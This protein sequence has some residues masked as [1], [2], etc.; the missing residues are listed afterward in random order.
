M[1][2]PSEHPLGILIDAMALSSAG[3]NPS[4]AI[5]MQEA[6]GQAA[7][8]NS[9]LLPV[10][11]TQNVDRWAEFDIDAPD[12]P[13]WAALGFVLGPIITDD[14]DKRGKPI[15][16]EA[17]LPPGWAREASDH[18]MWSYISDERGRRRVSIFY[19]AAFYDRSAHA[20]I[21]KLEGP[22]G[23]VYA[24]HPYTEKNDYGAYCDYRREG[25]QYSECN[26]EE[27]FRWHWPEAECEGDERR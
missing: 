24:D 9:T 5:E 18:N 15:F 12:N 20:N 25:Q 1:S 11:G 8:V 22:N 19:K 17:T 4:L 21:D 14:L 26:R 27:A 2:L 13:K 23:H 10:T 16:R 7:L 3:K 6:R